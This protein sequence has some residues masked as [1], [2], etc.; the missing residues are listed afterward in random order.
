MQI[1]SVSQ[2][3]TYVNETFRAIW[4]PTLVALEGEVA[5]FRVS[6]GQW[7]NFVLKDEDAVVSAFMV[8]RNLTVPVQD[9]M[10]VRAYGYPRIYPKYGKFSFSI[11]R[12][13]LVGEGT[14]QKALAMLRQKLAQEGLF[15]QGRKRAL[16]PFPS[17]I[18]LVA[19]R[20]SAAYGDFL[21]ILEER[22]SGLEVDV[23]HVQVQGEHAP[24]SIIQAIRAA[25]ADPD[26][27][28]VLVL[29]RGGGSLEDLMAFNDERVV[30]ALFSSRIPTLVGI[31]HERDV[32]LSEEVADVR[33][34]TPTDCAR[35]LVPDKKDVLYSIA[36]METQVGDRF[37][38]MVEETNRRI[39]A[40]LVSADHWMTRISSM[41]DR[42][43][44][45][46]RGSGMRWLERLSDRLE[47]L[48]RLIRSMDPVLVLQRGYVMVTDATGRVKR[49]TKDFSDD[50]RI[51]LRV[52]DGDI[53]AIANPSTDRR[54]PNNLSFFP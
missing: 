53:S 11:D 18:A 44:D 4:D 16:P 28:D 31:G 33:G 24:E 8:L 25:N 22:W 41:I 26:R 32:T 21:R 40:F 54:K 48:M 2:F 45:T 3:V 51:T 49:S 38:R 14:L 1:F 27:Y 36:T 34:S 6:Q 42:A 15:D 13:E 50:E 37:I 17:R 23:Y 35:R 29:T 47:S 30:R 46:V 19:S 39:D 10:R 12:I 7:V 9:G 43:T 5:E 52:S 20:E